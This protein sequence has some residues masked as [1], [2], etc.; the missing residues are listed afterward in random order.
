MRVMDLRDWPPQPGGAFTAG[1]IFPQSTEEVYVE[2]FIGI[3]AGHI[4]FTCRFGG[5]SFSY[6]FPVGDEK[7]EK[8]VEIIM[9]NYG[10][11]LFDVGLIKIPPD[12]S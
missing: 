8:V 11:R 2:R 7:R 4:V 1:T 6:D 12:E 10:K 3:M 5:D 9:G